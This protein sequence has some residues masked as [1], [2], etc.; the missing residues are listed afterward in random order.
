[1]SSLP[2]LEGMPEE[3]VEAVVQLLE[4]SDTCSLR[5]SCR[6]IAAKASRGRFRTFFIVKR[7]RLAP[8]G[9]VAEFAHLT[10]PESLGCLLRGLTIVGYVPAETDDTHDNHD[11]S[12]E[13]FEPDDGSTKLADL[14]KTAFGNLRRNSPLR[15]LR[16]LSLEVDGQGEEGRQSPRLVFT[17]WPRTWETAGHTFRIA[18]MTLAESGLLVERLDVFGNV[19]RCSLAVD[20]IGPVLPHVGIHSSLQNLRHLTLSLSH[21]ASAGI[22]K[23]ESRSAAMG[24]DHV[25]DVCRFIQ[26]CT[27]LESLDL[28]WFG[29]G[30]SGKNDAAL[31]EEHVFDRITEL[32]HLISLTTCVLCGITTTEA[33]L[34]SFLANQV[35]LQSMTMTGIQLASGHWRPIFDALRSCTRLNYLHFDH[36]YENRLISFNGA[37]GKPDFPSVRPTGPNRITREGAEA[38]LPVRYNLKQGRP[39]GSPDTGRWI[40]E[41]HFRYGPPDSHDGIAGVSRCI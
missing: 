2:S 6:D 9:N 39:A 15:C 10:Q 30:H 27:Q 19:N 18:M 34:L 5:Q 20:K 37:P 14:L 35:Q 32:A 25:E 13:H 41:Q 3:L 7:V 38:R 16:S 23:V 33:A 40:R 28:H 11:D 1:M 31:E 36:L 21:H 17:S 12:D 8:D 4:L 29:L 22:D 24:K 26:S